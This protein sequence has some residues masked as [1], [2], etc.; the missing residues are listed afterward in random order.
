MGDYDLSYNDTDSDYTF[1]GSIQ[2]PFQSSMNDDYSGSSVWNNEVSAAQNTLNNATNYD[3]FKTNMNSSSN[4]GSFWDSIT[5]GAKDLWGEVK[6]AAGKGSTWMAL[7]GGG[8][9]LYDRYSANADQEEALKRSEEGE[10][11]K[12]L[13][14]LAKLKYGAKGGGGGGGGAGNKSYLDVINALESSKRGQGDAIMGLMS[15]LTSAYK[16]G[17]PK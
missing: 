14:E 1:G 4:D 7:L 5:G 15:G 17:V 2:N 6:G 8:K 13:M 3:E 11:M 9:D 12:F 16:S 10:K